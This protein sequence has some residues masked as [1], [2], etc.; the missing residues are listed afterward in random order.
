MGKIKESIRPLENDAIKK[1]ISIENIKMIWRIK[2]PVKLEEGLT[3]IIS[4]K[5]DL[6]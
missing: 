5:K 3:K 2:S 1:I 4:T 6:I